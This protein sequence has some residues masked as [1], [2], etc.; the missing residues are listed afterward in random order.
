[1][2]QE[3]VSVTKSQRNWARIALFCINTVIWL[4]AVKFIIMLAKWW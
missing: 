4:Q 2:G 1:M 3:A